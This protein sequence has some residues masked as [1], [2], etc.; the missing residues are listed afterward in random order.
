M[1]REVAVDV[2]LGLAVA[3]AAASSVGVLAMR[4]AYQKLHYLTPLSILAPVLVGLAVLV[5]AG[6]STRS[7]QTWLAVGFLVIAS[8][9]LSHATI[10]AARI[11]AEGDWRMTAGGDGARQQDKPC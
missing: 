4:D 8:P 3:I 7:A 2:L 1:V 9:F 5:E 10:R 6:Y 11:R